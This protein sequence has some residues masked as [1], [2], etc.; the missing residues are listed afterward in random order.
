MSS[1]SLFSSIDHVNIQTHLAGESF[2]TMFGSMTVDL[3]RRQLEPGDHSVSVFAL[4]GS[5]TVRVPADV[6][7]H[8]ESGV[9]MG[10]SSYDAR[11][12]DD[13]PLPRAALPEIDFATAAVRLRI[14]ATAIFGSVHVVRVLMARDSAPASTAEALPELAD[15]PHAYEGDTR[16]IGLE[17]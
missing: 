14:T 9:L 5:I 15:E 11:S 6:G 16:R 10:Q 4:F 3:T 12:A 17:I 2:T 8:V 7:L 1:T 13:R